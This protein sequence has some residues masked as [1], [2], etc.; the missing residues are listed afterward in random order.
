MCFHNNKLLLFHQQKQTKNKT[1]S[2]FHFFFFCF[3]KKRDTAGQER[4]RNLTASFYRG[5]HGV[6]IVM[7]LTDAEGLQKAEG[8]RREIVSRDIL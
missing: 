5:F 1:H 7:N 6:M 3:P 4:F 8:K 2:H